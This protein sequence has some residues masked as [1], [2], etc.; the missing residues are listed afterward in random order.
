MNPLAPDFLGLILNDDMM[1]IFLYNIKTLEENPL[2][3]FLGIE[4]CKEQ[5]A[6]QIHRLFWVGIK[7]NAFVSVFKL[8]YGQ[9]IHL[10][11]H[12]AEL[13]LI[14]VINFVCM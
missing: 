9:L 6:T 5:V 4:I 1:K 11:L 12:A 7:V 2:N 8:L 14:L 13:Q 10:G 3:V